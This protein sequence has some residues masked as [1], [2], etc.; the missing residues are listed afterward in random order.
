MGSCEYLTLD[1][2][3]VSTI[4]VI[5]AF[6]AKAVAEYYRKKEGS[7]GCCDIPE[8]EELQISFGNK[9]K[10]DIENQSGLGWTL[11]VTKKEVCIV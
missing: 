5:S 3:T 8:Y 1:S 11:L 2:F 4:Y 6:D 7:E 10:I 9:V